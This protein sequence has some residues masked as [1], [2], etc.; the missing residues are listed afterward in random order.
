MWKHKA[1]S[2]PVGAKTLARIDG[3][4]F[5]RRSD[6]LRFAAEH[7]GALSANFLAAV[8]FKM[9]KGQVNN[10]KQLTQV[11]VAEWASS[12]SSSGLTE[13]RDVREAQTLAAAMEALNLSDL[14]RA[15]DILAM[16]LMALQRAKAKGG[17]WEKAQQLELIPLPGSEVGPAGLGQLL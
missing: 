5:K 10:S 8:R 2:R 11:P 12:S 4:K 16:R 14:S 1:K 17:S 9:G 15:M 6:L 7:K 3:E 13:V